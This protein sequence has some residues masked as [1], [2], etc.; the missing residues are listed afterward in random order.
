MPSEIDYIILESL[1][2][3]K[4]NYNLKNV[5]IVTLNEDEIN[6]GRYD[7]NDIIESD[8]SVSRHHAILK[9]DKITGKL[10]LV[11]LAK[12]GTL[13]LIK[14]NI[15]MKEKNIHFQILLFWYSNIP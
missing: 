12:F 13:I 4:D 8:I 7:T 14:G 15:K 10:H 6:I 2:F 5:Y 11:N 1:D 9:F 3:I